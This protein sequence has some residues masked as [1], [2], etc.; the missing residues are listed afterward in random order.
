MTE[1][2]FPVLP[3]QIN[4][5]PFSRKVFHSLDLRKALKADENCISYSCLSSSRVMNVDCCREDLFNMVFN[6]APSSAV[7]DSV[8]VSVLE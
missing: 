2:P 1:T 7:V 3:R 8:N 6:H 4:S 5:N